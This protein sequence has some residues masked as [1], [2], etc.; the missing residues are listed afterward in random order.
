MSWVC[1]YDTQPIIS[2]KEKADFLKESLANNYIYYFYHDLENQCCT[3]KDTMK[4]IRA[5]ETFDL[6]VIT[7]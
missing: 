4:G 6:S 1:G 3:L 2:L 7:G 5:A